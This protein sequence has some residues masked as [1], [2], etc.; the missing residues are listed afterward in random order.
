MSA[1][2]DLV[3]FFERPYR[4]GA[5]VPPHILGDW[6]AVEASNVAADSTADELLL[7]L[8]SCPVLEKLTF[9]GKCATSVK[10]V[11]GRAGTLSKS[12]FWLHGVIQ[13]ATLFLYGMSGAECLDRLLDM[14]GMG[15]IPSGVLEIELEDLRN[16][17]RVYV[18]NRIV[19][20]KVG[21]GERMNGNGGEEV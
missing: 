13:H 17:F 21:E 10:L 5:Y 11:P 19:G 20:Q 8:A 15:K 14:Q 18:R 1:D 2:T 3:T 6:D 7:G 9:S 4:E 12:L 16:E